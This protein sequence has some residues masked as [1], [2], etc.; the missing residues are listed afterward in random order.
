MT[1]ST[2]PQTGHRVGN[3]SG[4]STSRYMRRFAFDGTSNP[5]Y[6]NR[7]AQAKSYPTVGQGRW[8]HRVAFLEIQHKIDFAPSRFTADAGPAGPCPWRATA[9]RYVPILFGVVLLL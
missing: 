2:L 5:S 1:M 6:R 8:V 3:R 4:P 9:M 7:D